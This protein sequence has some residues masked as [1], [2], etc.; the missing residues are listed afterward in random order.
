[1]VGL[2]KRSLQ[3]VVQSFAKAS[4]SELNR[5]LNFFGEET[6]VDEST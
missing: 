1:M 6:T 2:L 3:A 4:D 5:G